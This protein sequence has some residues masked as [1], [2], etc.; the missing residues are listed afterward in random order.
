MC[1]INRRLKAHR[2]IYPAIPPGFTVNR[3]LDFLPI[4]LERE[5]VRSFAVSDSC[6]AGTGTPLEKL[7]V[8][9]DEG[10]R[11]PDV[12]LFSAV[13]G[14]STLCSSSGK[15]MSSIPSIT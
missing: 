8:D 7:A 2:P 13:G 4:E 12:L 14:F 10:T 15:E 5:E 11:V 1:V 3:C 6:F 9:P